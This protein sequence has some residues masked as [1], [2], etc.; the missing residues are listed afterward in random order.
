MEKKISEMPL[1]LLRICA[2]VS[3]SSLLLSPSNSTLSITFI[4][5]FLPNICM[6]YV[7][8]AGIWHQHNMKGTVIFYVTT[9]TYIVVVDP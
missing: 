4:L 3:G 1:I 2:I 5:L 8:M 6:D 9:T 7:M